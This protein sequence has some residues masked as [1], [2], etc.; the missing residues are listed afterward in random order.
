MAATEPVAVLGAGGTMGFAMARNLARAGFEVRAWNRSRAKAEPL[1]DDGARICDTA[2][3]AA[4][5]A[6][7]VLTILADT[8]AVIQSIE[9][10]LP[11][12]GENAIWLQASTI[13][14]AGTER[15]IELAREHGVTF[16]DAPVLGT[17]Q[18]AEEGKLVILASGPEEVK[19]RLQ[20]IFDTIGQKTLW[21]GEAGAGTRLKIVTNSWVLTV[22]EAAAEAIALAE[23]LDLDPTLLFAAIEGGPLELPYLRMKGKAMLERNFEPSFRLGLAAKDAGLIEESA[24]RHGLDLPMFSAIR[25]RM[26]EAAKEH[27]DKDMSATY[28]ASAPAAP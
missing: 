9:G 11:N 15:C 28:L 14:E 3:E 24:K 26:A 22:V 23:A 8:D 17:K 7:V 16:V 19:G 21:I 1:A 6:A 27:A 12:V 25:A 18:P 20:P 10:A 5:G 4:D 13:G 2:G